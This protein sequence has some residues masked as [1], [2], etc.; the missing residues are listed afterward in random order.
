MITYEGDVTEDDKR[1]AIENVDG[2]NGEPRQT[3]TLL[4]SL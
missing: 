1:E 4:N 3:L 2:I